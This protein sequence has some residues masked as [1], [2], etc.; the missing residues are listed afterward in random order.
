MGDEVERVGRVA[1]RLGHLAAQAVAHYTGEVDVREGFSVHELVAGYYHARYPEEDDVR[2][3]DEVGS[4]VVVFDFGIFR[5]QD[6]VEEGDGPQP[7]GE[8]CVEAVGVLA[9]VGER[10]LGVACLFDGFQEGFLLVFGHHEATL[11]QVPCRDAVSPPQLA[12]DAPVADGGH[13]VAVGIAEFLRHEFDVALFHGGDG[14]LHQLLHLHEPLHGEL[15]LDNGVGALGVAHLVVVVLHFLHEV[16]PGEVFHNLF[17]H[18][19]AVHTGVEAGGFRDGAVVVEDV[20][21]GEVVFLAEHIVVNI[22]GRGDFQATGAEVH[23]HIFVHDDGYG[24]ADHRHD[25]AFTFQPG[26]ALVVGV[27]AHGRVAQNCFGTRRSHHDIAPFR[28]VLH[29]VAQVEELGFLLLVYNLLVAESREC[30]GVPVHHAHSAVD[31][32]L[33]V[34][35]V[36]DADYGAGARFVHGEGGAFPVAGST[37]FLELFEDDAAVFV[38]PVPGVLQELFAREVGFLDSVG[39]EFGH[40]FGF[41]RDGGMVGAGHP[42]GVFARHAGTADEDVLDGV[43]EHVAHVQHAGDVGRRDYYAVGFTVIGFAVEEAVLHPVGIP[44]VLDFRGII[45]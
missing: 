26:V 24:A 34:K 10:E 4:G 39:G 2:C 33:F 21:A 12:R 25:D 5:F 44:F 29:A 43:V 40:H 36:E 17:A 41:R 9:Q 19:E 23:L 35:A 6:S 30:L 20:D 38:G 16:G 31:V 18:V 42:Q 1:E 7:G 37:E 27:Y 3:G 8:P 13:P 14:R 28:V 15:R 32:P 22:V 11:W 45:F